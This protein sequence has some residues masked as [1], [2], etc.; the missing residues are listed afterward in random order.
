MRILYIDMDSCRADHLGCYGYARNTSPAID[1]LAQDAALFNRCYASDVPCL[2]S[3][4]A[5]F[6]GQ[7]GYRTG[8]VGH[9]GTASQRIYRGRTFKVRREDGSFPATLAEA[10][11]HT[12]SVSPFVMRHSAFHVAHGFRELHDTGHSG[13]ETADAINATALPWLKANARRERWFLHVNYWDPHRTYRTPLEYGN[14][15]KDAPI[16]DWPD[17]ATLDRHLAGYG[18]RSA[19]ECNVWGHLYRAPTP[20]EVNR[21]ATREDFRTWIDGYDVGIR[22]MDDHIGQ[23][24]EALDAAG[25]LDE[26]IIVLSADHAESQGE[27]NAY[28][29]HQ[30]ADEAVA[31]IPLIVRVPGVTRGQRID[32]LLY[33]LDLAPTLCELAGAE[34]FAKWDGVSFAPALR[35]EAW[36]GRPSLVLTQGAHVRQRGVRF[37]NWLMLR[38]YDPGLKQLPELLLF[39]VA[40]DPRETRDLS[41]ARPDVVARGDRILAEWKGQFKEGGQPLPDPL[42]T[43]A[44][45]GGPHHGRTDLDAYC[46]WLEK[47]GKGAFIEEIRRR[48]P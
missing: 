4:T 26:T 25:V 41:A 45:E 44:R 1:A 27:L 6:S 34:V 2:P 42:D 12:C 10:G 20:R 5:L 24:V 23:L 9:A 29:D 16:P 7:F 3:R 19:A 38:T 43:V 28:G 35:G 15:F 48:N 32:G 21:I 17:Q 14:P 33:Q 18:S 40:A 11:W 22:Y 37:E 13:H 30:V 31:H 46:A 36:A 8:V 39:D 47:E